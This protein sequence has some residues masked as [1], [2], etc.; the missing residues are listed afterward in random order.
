MDRNQTFENVLYKEVI[1]PEYIPLSSA[2][3]SLIKKLLTK[4]DAKRLGSQTGASEIKS[5]PFFKTISWPLLRNMTPPIIPNVSGP[6]DTSNFR[7]I[8][9]SLESK[10][11][12]GSDQSPPSEEMDLGMASRSYANPFADFESVSINYHDR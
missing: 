1:F 3:R 6:S 11:S 10:K 5:H 4:S 2:G 9:E 7:N 12:S 8:K